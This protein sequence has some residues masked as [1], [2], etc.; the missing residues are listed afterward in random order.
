VIRLCLNGGQ[1]LVKLRGMRRSWPMVAIGIG[2]A[3][4]TGLA[5]CVWS[6]AGQRPPTAECGTTLSGAGIGPMPAVIDAT[7]QLPPGGYQSNDGL[8]YLRV[9][10]GCDHGSHVTW[11]PAAAAR[12]VKA[13]Y[14][15]DGLPAVVVL[16][17]CGASASFR[18]TATRN[19]RVVA[20]VT[21]RQATTLG[22]TKPACLDGFSAGRTAYRNRTHDLRI[23]RG[24]HIVPVT[25]PAFTAAS[26]SVVIAVD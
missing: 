26:R 22:G 21:V 13:A 3:V 11:V 23:T 7:Y 10:R 8:I 18:L 2:C 15:N 25:L 1:C 19:G 20:S 17:P 6:S 9:A 16:Q 5:G 14:A 4:A 24:V 12:L